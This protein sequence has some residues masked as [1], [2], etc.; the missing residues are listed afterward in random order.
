MSV[1]S[2]C[3]KTETARKA[4]STGQVFVALTFLLTLLAL[5]APQAMAEGEYVRSDDQPITAANG[6][7]AAARLDNGTT[8]RTRVHPSWRYNVGGVL[9]WQKCVE[10]AG[11]DANHLSTAGFRDV[12][13]KALNYQAHGRKQRKEKD[14][15]PCSHGQVRMQTVKQLDSPEGMLVYLWGLE[16]AAIG[17][18]L[19]SS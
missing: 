11:F 17:T 5:C 3:V 8:S 2:V 16:A 18:S 19:T 9:H 4:K 6:V 14:K 12:S 7:S 1:T 13:G 10:V 15:K